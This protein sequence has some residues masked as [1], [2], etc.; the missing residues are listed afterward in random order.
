MPLDGLNAAA[1]VAILNQ[2]K[3]DKATRTRGVI[4]SAF[5]PGPLGLAVPVILARNARK[6][7]GGGV[8]PPTPAPDQVVVPD[9]SSTRELTV[10]QAT[11]KLTSFRHVAGEVETY[12]EG[13]DKDN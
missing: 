4:L 12:G 6:S 10:K 2:P 11:E 8:V 5:V 1:A 9:V 3:I 7:G 13:G